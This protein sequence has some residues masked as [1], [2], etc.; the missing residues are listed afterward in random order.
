MLHTVLTLGSH[1]FIFHW[2]TSDMAHLGVCFFLN[3]E[4]QLCTHLKY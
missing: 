2:F 1:G 3:S 4:T